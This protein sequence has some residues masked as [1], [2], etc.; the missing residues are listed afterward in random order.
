LASVVHVLNRSP[1]PGLDVTP[2]EAPKGRRPEDAGFRNWGIRAWALT[3]KKQQR[4]LEPRTDVGRLVGSTAGGKAYRF[5]EDETNQAFEQRDVL[6]EEDLAKVEASAV[7]SSAGPRLTAD[8]DGDNH[9]ATEGATDILDAERGREDEYAPADTYD[10]DDKTGP[11]SI[12][13]DRVGDVEVVPD[14]S[15][16]AGGQGPASCDSPAP[17]PRRSKRKPTSKVTWWEKAPKAFLASGTK[18]AAESD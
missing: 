16:P 13:E 14:G 2:L 7:A 11:V 9:D 18:S 6:I 5:L 4:K 12:A 3:L 1:K 15:T 8:Y 10:S 17:G